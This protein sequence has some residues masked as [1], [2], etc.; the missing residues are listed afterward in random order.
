ME[1]QAHA[2]VVRLFPYDGALGVNT[3]KTI[4]LKS[5][6]IL[7]F[8]NSF[9]VQFEASFHNVAPLCAGVFYSI[10]FVAQNNREHCMMYTI[11][12]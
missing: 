12:H 11:Q 6:E 4:Y 8:S 9:K 3:V 5:G 2:K 10:D 1:V 7:M